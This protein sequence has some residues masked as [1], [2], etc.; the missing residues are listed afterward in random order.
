MFALLVLYRYFMDFFL[1][2]S[3]N[4]RVISAFIL[5]FEFLAGFLVVFAVFVAKTGF[6]CVFSN[7]FLTQKIPV[8]WVKNERRIMFFDQKYRILPVF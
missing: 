8:F 4:F 1:R 2:F 7:K 6:L 3:Q 5:R